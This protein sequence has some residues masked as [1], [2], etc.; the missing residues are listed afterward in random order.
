MTQKKIHLIVSLIILASICIAA[1]TFRPTSFSED[2][3]ENK[4]LEVVYNATTF[5]NGEVIHNTKQYKLN[6]DS[7]EFQQIKLIFK[8]YS[9]HNCFD[10]LKGGS[11]AMGSA[12]FYLS[13]EGD[14]ILIGD[15]PNILV[16]NKIYRIGYWGSSEINALNVDLKD[17]L[18]IE[19]NSNDTELQILG[20]NT[21]NIEKITIIHG[22]TMLYS[23]LTL[24]KDLNI[25][26]ENT[27][28]RIA[29]LDEN[30]GITLTDAEAYAQNDADNY[31][32]Y[33]TFSKEQTLSFK[34][35][36]DSELLNCDGV[37]FDTN[38]MKLN[39]SKDGD[40]VGTMGYV[41]NTKS[42]ELDFLTF[43]KEI[44]KTFSYL[45]K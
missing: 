4:T 10:T 45:G 3:F 20:V 7:P 40:F 39:W 31:Y 23:N 44:K 34:N 29:T 14:K 35:N 2:F 8:K 1:Y 38:N 9:Y 17:I 11:I 13:C 19:A 41:D 15:V 18:N 32:V 26:L 5:E 12:W 24:I 27:G 22:T 42:V 6:S 21:E 25:A 33:I 16:G 28:D 43:V 36:S 30:L 37:L